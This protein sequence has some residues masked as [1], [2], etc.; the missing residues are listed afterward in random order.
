MSSRVDPFDPFGEFLRPQCGCDP[1]TGIDIH[2]NRSVVGA[3]TVDARPRA[4]AGRCGADGVVASVIVG[5]RHIADGF[6]DE[7]NKRRMQ[8]KIIPLAVEI[9]CEEDNPATSFAATFA[10]KLQGCAAPR[11]AMGQC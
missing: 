8:R 6:D 11:K 5:S 10:S 9:G 1:F 3:H 4:S 2:R 7:G